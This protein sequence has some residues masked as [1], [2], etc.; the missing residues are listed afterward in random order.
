MISFTLYLFKLLK[1][2]AIEIT[3]RKMSWIFLVISLRTSNFP[4]K[5]K[6]PQKYKTL[7]FTQVLRKIGTFFV[8]LNLNKIVLLELLEEIFFRLIFFSL[9]VFINTYIYIYSN[10]YMFRLVF[11]SFSKTSQ[12]IYITISVQISWLKI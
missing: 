7:F 4:P 6:W 3:L 5:N 8:P 11:G 1:G 10:S 12:Y 2:T 9:M